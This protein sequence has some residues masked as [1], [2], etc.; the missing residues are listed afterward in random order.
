MDK[1][2]PKTKKKLILIPILLIL[3]VITSFIIIFLYQLSPVDSK[4]EEIITF[5]V[6]NGW[7]KSKIVEE[8]KD[9]DLIRSNFF[10]KLIMKL[11]NVELYAGTYK[12]SKD[13]STN[14]ILNKISNHENIENETITITFVEGKRLS[15]FVEQISNNFEFTEE[16]INEKV[17]N[18]DYL[19]KLIEKYWFITD[20]IYN[21]DIYNPLEGYL[22]PDTYEF[23]KNSTIEE[24]I[25]KILN[26]MDSKLLDYKDD[27][28]V[29]N[30]SIHEYLTLASIVEL[31]GVNSADRAGV[32]GVFYNR[33]ESGMTLGSDVTTYYAVGKDFSKEL[34]YKDLNSCNGYNTRGNCVKG[35]PVGPICNAGL[36]S[37]SAVIEPE[38]NEYYYF[39]ADKNKKTYF[40]KDA[41]EHSETV[42]KLKNEGLWYTY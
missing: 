22:Y 27:I 41:V 1:I 12:L 7:G 36:S 34:T 5:T 14:E 17:N 32:A 38:D 28:E 6:K 11:K 30:Y 40:S 42:S 3:I 24:I 10:G 4:N 2:N 25:E 9:A 8:L 19:D 23:K 31:E 26:N 15:Y 21:K 33:L 29:G 35:L 13:L 39:V 18:L 16:E 37:I 20:K